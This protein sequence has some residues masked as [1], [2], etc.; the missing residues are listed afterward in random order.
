MAKLL[1]FSASTRKDSLNQ[2]LAT[3][4]ADIADELGA[5][6]TRLDLKQYP[7]PIYNGDDEAANGLPENA[8]KL[9]ELFSEHDGIF[10]ATP[11]YNRSIPAL[12]KNTIDWISRAEEGESPLMAL[13]GKVIGLGAVSIG[14]FMGVYSLMHL[15]MI[16]TYMGIRVIPQQIGMGNAGDAFDEKGALKEERQQKQLTGV[17]KALISAID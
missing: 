5:N 9:K 11:E 14:P 7:L 1:I 15:R 3:Q 6:V 4:A 13:K 16:F 8:K 2:K 12:L 17:I 10:I